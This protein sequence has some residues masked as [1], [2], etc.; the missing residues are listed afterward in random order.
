MMTKS[1]PSPNAGALPSLD[2]PKQEGLCRL[3]ATASCPLPSPVH[4]LHCPNPIP[5][6][7]PGL[8]FDTSISL[9]E[10]TVKKESCSW[11]SWMSKIH[12]S[13]GV[14]LLGFSEA[15]LMGITLLPATQEHPHPQSLQFPEVPPFRHPQLRIILSH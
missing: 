9:K 3:R 1:L 13:L 12:S 15:L 5:V 8:V 7:P 10:D 4:C 14:L 2:Q 11:L 6:R